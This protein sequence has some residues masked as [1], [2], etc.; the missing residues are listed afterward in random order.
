L[1]VAE[2]VELEAKQQ[3]HGEEA[4]HARVAKPQSAGALALNASPS[5]STRG[6]N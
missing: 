6:E 5:F 2:A 4:L 1:P 3:E